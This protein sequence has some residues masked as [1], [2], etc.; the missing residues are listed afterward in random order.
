MAALLNPKSRCLLVA[1]L[2]A[3]YPAF[4]FSSDHEYVD[5]G[6]FKL[7]SEKGALYLIQGR[8]YLKSNQK[9]LL[10]QGEFLG[11]EIRADKGDMDVLDELAKVHNNIFHL[12]IRINSAP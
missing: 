10:M 9:A 5:L 6:K 7:S 4:S 11:V 3:T 1:I 8:P 2:L 12:M